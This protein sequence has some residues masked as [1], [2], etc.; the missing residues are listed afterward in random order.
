M[1]ISNN[2]L[3]RMLGNIEAKAAM[4]MAAIADLKT[5]VVKRLDDH[6]KRLRDLEKGAAK[7]GAIAGVG[8]SLVVAVIVE[9]IKRKMGQ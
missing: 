1:E 4:H 9:T 2:D 3:A 6:E 8:A 5:E 7:S